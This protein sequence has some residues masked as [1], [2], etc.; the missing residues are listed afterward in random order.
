M[1]FSR[2]DSISVTFQNSNYREVVHAK[3][4]EVIV[5]E[6]ELKVWENNLMLGLGEVSALS[7]VS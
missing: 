7:A 2:R 4:F 5:R 6:I 1:T 3:R